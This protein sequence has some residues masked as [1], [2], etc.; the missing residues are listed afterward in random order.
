MKIGIIG[1]SG[2]LG[3]N[4]YESLK[5]EKSLNII[6]FSSFKKEKKNWINKV[7]K[8][9]CLNKP[10]VII[11]CSS[12][13]LLNDDEK[14]IKQLIETNITSQSIFLKNALKNKKF[15]SLITFGTKWELDS[16]GK[17]K[18][19][20]FYAATKLAADEILK[21]FCLDYKLSI[22]SLKIFDTYGKNDKRKKFLNLLKENYKRNKL[23][24]M[25][26]GNQILDLININD[27][28]D[29]VKIILRDIIKKKKIGFFTY[30]VSSKKSIKL[31]NLV[32]KLIPTLKKKLKISIGSLKYRSKETMLPM[33]KTFNYPGWKPKR[34]LIKELKKIFDND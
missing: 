8:E 4:L 26:A 20:N 27:L 12:S 6:Q 15:K 14:S 9:I 28:V 21:L 30:T 17:N 16:K 5:K 13:Q 24:K 23:F 1:A 29:L 19:L 25:T 10:E 2:F 7:S 11:N 34:K 31:K 33:Q 32:K 18:P 3:K 22:Y